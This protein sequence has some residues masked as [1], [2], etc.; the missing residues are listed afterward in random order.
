MRRSVR[1][2]PWPRGFRGSSRAEQSQEHDSTDPPSH[3]R[4]T[5]YEQ[6]MFQSA[7]PAG[8]M[9]GLRPSLAVR[10]VR[11]AHFP[12]D[13]EALPF[14]GQVGTAAD[15][16]PPGV[17]DDGMLAPHTPFR[18]RRETADRPGTTRKERRM[19]VRLFVGG[20]S[21]S[22]STDRLREAFARFGVVDSAAVMTDRET[23]RSR[24]FGFVE[25]ASTDE[26][27]RAIG[28]LNGSNL[29]GRT[30]R[31][32]KATPRGAAPSRSPVGDRRPDGRRPCSR[33]RRRLCR[34]PAS[35]RCRWRASTGREH[36]TRWM[37]GSGAW[38]GPGEPRAWRSLVERARR[39]E[40]RSPA[41]WRLPTRGVAPAV[42]VAAPAAC[43]RDPVLSVAAMIEAGAASETTSAPSK[44][45]MTRGGARS[46][47]G[48]LSRGAD[49]VL[50]NAR[51]D[52]DA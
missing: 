11:A 46:Y 12:V 42:K 40:A 23:G 49:P 47:F 1:H 31:V 14:S 13:H 20:L 27:E 50:G 4:T 26:A 5:M 28:S 6:K 48:I 32:D 25:M 36:E 17:G 37:A 2:P 8:R 19:S 33:S 30:I 41:P 18:G 9:F 15:A 10:S 52:P 24:G 29:D 21:F 45:P 39:S 3:R 16:M 35:R 43:A 22:T 44:P 51:I 34:P 7:L 38:R